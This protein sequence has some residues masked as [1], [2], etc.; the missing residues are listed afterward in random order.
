MNSNIKATWNFDHSLSDQSLDVENEEIMHISD[1][2]EIFT[3]FSLL[4]PRFVPSSTPVIFRNSLVIWN[5][6]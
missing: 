5:P 4:L 6:S 2:Q 3:W 1:R